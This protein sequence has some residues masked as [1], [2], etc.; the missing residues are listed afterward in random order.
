MV[1]AEVKAWRY[2][3]VLGAGAGSSLK[4][5]GGLMAASQECWLPVFSRGASWLIVIKIGLFPVAVKTGGEGTWD[6][7]ATPPE[8]ATPTRISPPAQEQGHMEQK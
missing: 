6:H 3:L 1:A 4:S 8:P 7:P 5:L 2:L